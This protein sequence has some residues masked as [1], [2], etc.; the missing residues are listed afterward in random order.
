MS[1]RG[2]RCGRGPE[3]SGYCKIPNTAQAKEVEAKMKA[4]MAER[5]A[6]DKRWSFQSAQPVDPNPP[7][8]RTVAGPGSSA[9]TRTS[10][11]GTKSAAVS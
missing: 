7:A 11:Q 10:V 1:C 6:Q 5:E 9:T 8:P 4:L 2:G 3:G